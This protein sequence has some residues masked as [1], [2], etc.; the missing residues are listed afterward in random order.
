MSLMSVRTALV[1]RVYNTGLPLV[2]R[3][4]SGITRLKFIYASLFED[5]IR[6]CEEKSRGKGFGTREAHRSE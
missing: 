5:W 1:Y 3:E 2:Y 6:S 4:V